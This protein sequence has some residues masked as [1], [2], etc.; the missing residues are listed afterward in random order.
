MW[1]L[2]LSKIFISIFIS[3]PLV[4]SA[5]TL[6]APDMKG[7]PYE[8]IRFHFNPTNCPSG[9]SSGLDKGMEL[10][11]SAPHSGLR[12]ERGVNVSYSVA[13]M[14]AGNYSEDVVVYCS[15]DLNADVGFDPNFISGVG[16]SVDS[17]SDG[18]LDQGILIINA[19]TTGAA[20]YQN[21]SGRFQGTINHEIG[22]VIGLGH[23]GEN[24][25]IM[26]FST[27]GKVG[28]S[29]HQDDID[30][31]R[32]LYPQDE[33]NGDYLFGCGSFQSFS[34][35]QKPSPWPLLWLFL[36]PVIVSLRPFDTY[37]KIKQ[38]IY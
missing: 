4:A 7:Y 35:H 9:V 27:S 1:G 26:F 25:A 2:M 18:R 24:K 8:T 36:L 19:S 11:N 17:D 33:W 5:F 3:F 38:L 30:G 12:L 32:H 10:W 22:H 21:S 37:A 16:G 28:E 23:S 31:V 29:L 20:S 34:N 14:V 13:D 6:T 15:T